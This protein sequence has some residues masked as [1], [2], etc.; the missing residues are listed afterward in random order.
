MYFSRDKCD[1]TWFISPLVES[2]M[3]VSVCIYMY[4]IY[5][6]RI[7][8][9]KREFWKFGVKILNSVTKFLLTMKYDLER[10]KSVIQSFLWWN[11]KFFSP[12]LGYNS[13]NFWFQ[14][15]LRGGRE[16][17]IDFRNRTSQKHFRKIIS[18][19]SVYPWKWIEDNLPIKR[20]KSSYIDREFFHVWSTHR[21]E[22]NSSIKSSK[23][24]L[25]GGRRKL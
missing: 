19:R 4:Y 5:Y 2:E 18:L 11:E 8:H 16:G 1:K 13:R 14:L 9:T 23:V 20:R 7:L 22:K 25:K 24:R 15:L 3:Y 10:T 6:I 17:K 12:F 21:T